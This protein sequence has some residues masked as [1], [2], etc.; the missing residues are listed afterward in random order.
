MGGFE[1]LCFCKFLLFD[2]G[3]AS[4]LAFFLFAS[5][6]TSRSACG[7][8]REKNIHGQMAIILDK[9][10]SL[11]YLS[12]NGKKKKILTLSRNPLYWRLNIFYFSFKITDFEQVPMPI[13]SLVRLV[14]LRYTRN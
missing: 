8:G 4:S 14:S 1:L 10:K 11:K 5:S 7:G 2:Y 12:G 13:L 6:G 3:Y 9:V